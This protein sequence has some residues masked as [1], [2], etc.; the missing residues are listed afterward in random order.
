VKE[1]GW[2][3]S[4]TDPSPTKNSPLVNTNEKKQQQSSYYFGLDWSGYTNGF[5]GTKKIDKLNEVI[6]C[7]DTFYQFDYNKVYTISS[8]IDEWKNGTGRGKFI[9]IKE[10]DSQDCEDT[11][12]KFPV[13]DGFKNFD[14]LFF[15]F[16]IIFTVIQP[17][18]LVLLTIAHILLWLYNVI[19]WVLCGLCNISIFGIRPFKWIC[20]TLNL[21]C[22]SSTDFTIRLPMITYPECQACECSQT[23]TSTRS[24]YPSII[25]GGIL[26][27]LS[28]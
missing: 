21:N 9:G 7:E 11:V 12:N 8:L 18:G 26:S 17:I 1:Y 22:S 28:I 13:N 14:F 25:P 10:I 16:S 24:I 4:I 5:I 15:L 6:N 2:M 20:D 23:L 19:I 3:N 27:Y